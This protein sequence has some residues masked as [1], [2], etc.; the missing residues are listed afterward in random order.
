VLQLDVACTAAAGGRPLS[1]CW[2]CW[3]AHEKV[4][5]VWVRGHHQSITQGQVCAAQPPPCTP[6]GLFL[7]ALLK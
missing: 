3:Q 1:T 5:G 2:A 6:P 7:M 4:V